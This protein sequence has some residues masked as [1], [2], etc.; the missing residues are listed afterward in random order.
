MERINE[1]TNLSRL[2]AGDVLQT[3]AYYV[4][5]CVD[6]STPNLS[7]DALRNSVRRN[8]QIPDGRQAFHFLTDVVHLT[9][10]LF[11]YRNLGFG[12]VR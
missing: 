9:F 2:A 10:S 3:F 1:E 12:N 6:L 5:I 4:D 8:Y 11:L 7:F